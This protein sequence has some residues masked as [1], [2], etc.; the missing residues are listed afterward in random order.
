MKTITVLLVIYGCIL[1]YLS[2]ILYFDKK[3]GSVCLDMFL[4]SF[5]DL[6]TA[7]ESLAVLILVFIV[8]GLFLTA[9]LSLSS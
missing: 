1:S 4:N 2:L 9:G 7:F 6:K 5:R 8:F 3:D